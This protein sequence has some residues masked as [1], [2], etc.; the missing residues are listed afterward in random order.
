MQGDP[1]LICLEP[2]VPNNPL[3]LLQCGCRTSWFHES[4]EHLWISSLAPVASILCPACRRPISLKTNYCFAWTAGPD[5]LK[6]WVCGAL[7]S[8]ELL[9]VLLAGTTTFY[10]FGCTAYILLL[11]FWWPKTIWYYDGYVSHAL[12]HFGGETLILALCFLQNTPYT[13]VIDLQLAFTMVHSITLTLVHFVESQHP[14]L[15]KMN[16]E[17]LFFCYAISREI[18]HA[19][20]LVS[21][22]PIPS[23][24]ER[25]KC[26]QRSRRTLL[27]PPRQS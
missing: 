2:A 8:L 1:C 14:G 9:Y 7:G 21:T 27:P 5:Q 16:L 18:Q 20:M 25:N 10:L 6:L 15:Q 12:I 17:T 13:Q 24:T 19:D 22:E 23:P 11:P 26:R 3:M 4:C